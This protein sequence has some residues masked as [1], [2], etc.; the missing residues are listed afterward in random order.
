MAEVRNAFLRT[1]GQPELS[2]EETAKARRNTP[3]DLKPEVRGRR[4]R[5]GAKKSTGALS[6]QDGVSSKRRGKRGVPNGVRSAGSENGFD[7]EA[8]ATRH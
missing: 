3:D 2:A 1:L 7:P 8:P 5:A 4:K 6:E